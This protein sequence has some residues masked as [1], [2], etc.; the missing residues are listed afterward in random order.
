MNSR[1]KISKTSKED[2]KKK[3]V[4]FISD[5]NKIV[6]FKGSINKTVLTSNWK[7]KGDFFEKYSIY[8]ESY[9]MVPTLESVGSTIIKK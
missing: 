2:S 5:Y 9:E 8:D 7:M 3:K 6:T 1:K 4:D